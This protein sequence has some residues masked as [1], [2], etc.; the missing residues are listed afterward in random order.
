MC[1]NK[2]AKKDTAIKI[3]NNLSK[4]CKHP[5]HL[6]GT[7]ITDGC[8]DYPFQY[9]DPSLN[10]DFNPDSIEDLANDLF[11]GLEGDQYKPARQLVAVLLCECIRFND[12]GALVRWAMRNVI[13]L[14]DDGNNG[15][16]ERVFKTDDGNPLPLAIFARAA[17]AELPT[18]GGK[19][20]TLA[21]LLN[22]IHVSY[23]A[24]LVH[25]DHPNFKK[26]LNGFN[27]ECLEET[28]EFIS[29]IKQS[30]MEEEPVDKDEDNDGEED[31][32]Y[33]PSAGQP[34]C[35]TN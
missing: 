20:Q 7:K 12:D 25:Y 28:G 16:F 30:R 3:L 27:A 23:D 29:D 13:R 32:S 35:Q 9:F 19:Q 1:K 24:S 5:E 11:K 21:L 6:I 31:I 34:G 33:I 14:F 2:V 10:P 22:D 8:F 26:L 15:A 17:S 4:P 18:Y